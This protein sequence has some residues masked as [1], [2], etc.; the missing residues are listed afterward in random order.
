[1]SGLNA[2]IGANIRTE[3][4]RQSRSVGWL[5]YA[6]GMSRGSLALRLDDAVSFDT[7]DLGAITEGLGVPIA[8]H[9]LGPLSVI[10]LRPVRT[11]LRPSLSFARGA[12]TLSRQD[13]TGCS[14]LRCWD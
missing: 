14:C 4:L 13:S 9:E 3:L 10:D 5:A 12:D 2:R 11:P 8:T 6:V 1:M 7:D